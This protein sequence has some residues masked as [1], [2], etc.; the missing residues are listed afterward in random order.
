MSHHRNK[1]WLSALTVD[2]LVI[3]GARWLL[4]AAL[5]FAP[6]AYGGTS[7]WAIETVNAALAAVL[8]LWVFG[9][10]LRQSWPSVPRVL[11]G[12]TL[13]LVA[14]AWFM[15]L[16]AQFDYNRAA[17][18]WIPLTPWLSFLPGSVDQSASFAAARR[19]SA[20]LLAVCFVCDMARRSVWRERLLRTLALN[21]TAFVFF[22]L[23]Q[24]LSGASSIYWGD[25]DAGK[26][27]FAAFRY[28][29][30]AGAFINLIWP[31]VAGFVALAFLRRSSW[32]KRLGWSAALIACLAGVL[33]SASRAATVLAVLLSAL[34]IGWVVWQATHGRIKGVSPSAAGVT[35]G[36]LLLL[37]VALSAMAGLDT[38]VHRWRRFTKDLS[39]SNPRL[40]VAQ[41]CF[42]MIPESGWCGFGPGTWQASFPYFAQ[43]VADR[44][45]GVWE[46]AHD[47]YL[48]TIIDWGMLGAAGWALVIFGGVIGSCVRFW[49]H[50]AALGH[51][52]RATHFAVFS[53]LFGVLLHSLVDFPLQI[54]SIQLC[55]AAL[56]GTMWAGRHWLREEE[57][58]DGPRRRRS[59][60]PA[61]ELKRSS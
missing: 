48:E 8:A 4:L 12:A 53:A 14:C 29:S 25:A 22:G 13:L 15:A 10:L 51:T 59:V 31:I 56:L 36:L 6:W 52:E 45:S 32:P 20:L 2:G 42:E 24:R 40:L 35:G 57:R 50:R 26:T 17:H 21:G 28:H 60:R 37:I 47:D 7:P 44:T 23:I 41:V 9:C 43:S 11:A 1:N 33:V 5:A 38:A 19:V 16:N 27:F 18:E 61:A 3:Q 46:H 49:R 30:N 55:F 54:M 34:W 58:T 39:I